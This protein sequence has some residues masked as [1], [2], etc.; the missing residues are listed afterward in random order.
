M[1]TEP[2]NRRIVVALVIGFA[3]V[4][5]VAGVAAI[6]ASDEP[7]GDTIDRN[8]SSNMTQTEFPWGTVTHET[9]PDTG[10]THVDVAVETNDSVSV[11][12]TAAPGATAEPTDPD[13]ETERFSWGM[14][15]Y[16]TDSDTGVTDV[17]VI[18]DAADDVSLAVTTVSEDGSQES[19]SIVTSAGEDGGASVSQSTSVSGSSSTVQSNASVS[20][21]TTASTGESIEIDIDDGDE[22]E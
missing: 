13:A 17:E 6:G 21:S 19:T 8:N 12:A 9:D 5:I 10:T 22:D 14:V 4:V 3:V 2:V 11:S 16:T 15:A 18:V 7:A 20:Q 1:L